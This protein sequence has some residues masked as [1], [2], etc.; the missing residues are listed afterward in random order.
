MSEELRKAAEQAISALKTSIEFANHM[1][2]GGWQP[3]AMQCHEAVASLRAA[4]A[5]PEQ[6]EPIA[7]A[8]YEIKY[9]G[10]RQLHWSGHQH[11]DDGDPAR[12]KCVPLFATPPRR[13]PDKRDAVLREVLALL[14]PEAPECGGCAAEWET[15]IAAINEVLD[16][17]ATKGN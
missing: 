12:Y 9:G 17:T 8:V 15:A 6:S 13:E 5:E 2:V 14:G 7:Y 3:T 11:S 1:G 10:S 4:L 16:N